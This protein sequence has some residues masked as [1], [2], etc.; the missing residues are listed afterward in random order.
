M[1]LSAHSAILMDGT[2]GQILYEKEPDQKSLVASTTKIMTALLVLERC[3][4][5]DTVE[6]PREAQ[7]VEGSSMYLKAGEKLSVEELLYGLM[8]SSGNDAAVT[9]AIH[10]SGSIEAF[11]REMNGKAKEL[12]LTHTH[13]ANPHG[14]DSGENYS[15]ARD[16]GK[17]AMEAMNHP[18]FSRIVS[19]QSHTAGQRTLV[20]HNKLLRLYSGAVGVKTG[21][22][23]KAGRILVGA[24]E[25]D[26]RRLI[27]VTINAPDDWDDHR[28]LFDY[29]FS[30][31]QEQVLVTGGEILGKVPLISG[32]KQQMDVVSAG[33]I[34]FPCLPGEKPE[35]RVYLPDFLYAPVE[36]GR[37]IGRAELFLGDKFVGSIPLITGETVSQLPEKPG[38][39]DKIFKKA[40]ICAHTYKLKGGA[41]CKN[42]CK[43]FSQPAELHHGEKGRK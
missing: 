41:S 15:T 5:T 30:M 7:G 24:A 35:I 31:Y 23:K 22:T 18:E 42:G 34:S 21:F 38:F 33:E 14:L 13:F 3:P 11:A 20:N 32:T 27:S 26:G 36:E 2:T 9:L 28:K 10:M 12:E 6:V 16:L 43:R 40:Q 8:L 19:T 25:K 39:W 29:G 37:E 17:L 4:L 1:E